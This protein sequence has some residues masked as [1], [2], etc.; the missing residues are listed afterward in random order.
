MSHNL[1]RINERGPNA[2]G[3]TGRYLAFSWRPVSRQTNLVLGPRQV[4]V[5]YNI[6]FSHVLYGF[7]VTGDGVSISN[8]TS[9]NP[10]PPG[11]WIYWFDRIEVP[12]GEYFIEYHISQDPTNTSTGKFV[13]VNEETGDY[14]GPICSMRDTQRSALAL[15]YFKAPKKSYISC[16]C[17]AGTVYQYHLAGYIRNSITITK[18]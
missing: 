9:H 2:Y 15:G 11:N 16:R 10:H 13:V 17:I 8:S 6:P 12:A 5:G 4:N 1:L 7:I 14:L 3:Q 18:L